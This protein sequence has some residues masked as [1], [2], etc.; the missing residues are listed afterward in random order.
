MTENDPG[1]R[2]E[3]LAAMTAAF[4]SAGGPVPPLPATLQS[5]LRELE[6]WCWSTR[7]ISGMAMYL[8][9]E[10]ARKVCMGL[11]PDYVAVSNA[12]P[13]K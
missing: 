10:P 4:G 5:G 2:L 3:G 11:V 12:G 6:A 8:F 7:S 9:R 13:R 1:V